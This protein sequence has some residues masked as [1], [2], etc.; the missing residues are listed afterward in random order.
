MLNSRIPAGRAIAILGAVGAALALSEPVF[1]ADPIPLIPAAANPP[2]AAA[3]PPAP[4]AHK[5]TTAVKQAPAP[6]HTQTHA[7]IPPAV[8]PSQSSELTPPPAPR[9]P[10]PMETDLLP[11]PAAPAPSVPPKQPGS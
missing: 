5:V 7:L 9:E 4:P 3:A 6:A 1:A 8:L 2:P 10:L 11:L